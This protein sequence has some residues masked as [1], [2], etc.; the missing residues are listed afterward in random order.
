MQEHACYVLFCCLRFSLD[1]ISE[2]S[3]LNDMANQ[4][5]PIEKAEEPPNDAHS[6]VFNVG[7]KLR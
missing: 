5:N 4:L 7:G 2:S 6:E 3:M 1:E